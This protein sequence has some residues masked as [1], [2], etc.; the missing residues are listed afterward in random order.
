MESRTRAYRGSGLQIQILDSNEFDRLGCFG[1]TGRLGN[2]LGVAVRR[3][4]LRPLHCLTRLLLFLQIIKTTTSWITLGWAMQI[5]SATNVLVVARGLSGVYW[6]WPAGPWPRMGAGGPGPPGPGGAGVGGAEGR[7]R[8]ERRREGGKET[9]GGR[10]HSRLTCSHLQNTF[11]RG[12]ARGV[13]RGRVRSPDPP[14]S[15]EGRGP[16]GP[17]RRQEERGA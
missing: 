5:R 2:V 13:G 10:F 8:A 14:K 12:V 6:Y 16:G 4:L 11:F 7:K 9:R 1:G 3:S 17:V 15:G